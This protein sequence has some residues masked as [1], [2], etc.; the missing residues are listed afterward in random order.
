MNY[1]LFGRTGLRV[2]ELCLGAMGFGTEWGTGADKTESKKVFSAF[3]NAGGTFI[4]TANRY[5]EG[6]SEL[7]LGEFSEGMRDRLVIA[8]KYSLYTKKGDLNDAGNSRKN[9]FRSV[10]GSLTRLNTDYIDILYLHAWDFTTPVE[11]VLRGLDDLVRMGKV[12][13]IAISDTPAWVIS[14]SLAISELRGW[15]SFAGV[16]LEY[17][18]IKRDAERDLI[19]MAKH[20]DLAVTAWA[21][22]GGGVLTGKYLDHSSS[23]MRIK[24]GSKR[25]DERNTGIAREVVRIASEAGVSPSSVA[26]NWL[27]AKGQNIFPVIG[28]R[29]EEQILDNL[30]CL[31]SVI[32]PEHMELLDKLSAIEPGFP[33]DFLSG[34]IATELL[35]GGMQKQFINHRRK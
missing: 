3:L 20:F 16:Q 21:P 8:T 14:N 7:F 4:D 29:K 6:S 22:L 33:H 11:E 10:E 13:Y 30:K 9:M 27:R 32:S 25:L 19:P 2:S 12:L 15:S 1:K 24:P 23:D 35:F 34:D 31:D 17:S 26:L 28:A 5:T 18:L